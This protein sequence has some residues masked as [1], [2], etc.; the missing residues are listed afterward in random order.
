MLKIKNRIDSELARF[1]ESADKF[2]SLKK[3]S[4]LLSRTI[5]DFVSREGKRVRPALFIIAYLGFTKNK[6]KNLY[7]SSLS[8]E[9]LHDFLLIHDDIIDKSDLRRNKPSMHRIFDKHLKRYNNLKFTGED[10]AIVAGDMLYALSIEALMSIKEDSKRKE[11]ALKKFIEAA[12]FTE[13]GEFIELLEGARGI[14]RV[15]KSTIYKIYDFKTAHYTFSSPLS[16]GAILAGADKKQIETLHQFGMSLGR[17]FQIRDDILNILAEEKETGKSTLTDLKEA[18]KTILIWFAYN[19]SGKKDKAF[20]KKTLLK[21]NI[22]R[23]N[24]LKMKKLIT[25]T[26]SLDYALR[27]IKSLLAKSEKIIRQSKMKLK[28]K[29]MLINYCGQ[30]LNYK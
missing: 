21:K 19:R 8:V 18:K 4:P 1:V 12:F 22:S 16:I 30:L 27:Q 25:D 29:N 14:D 7:R 26:G 28:Y 10:L 9:L 24:L 11:R 13:A 17:A 6:A 5:K 23:N 3:I 20:I 2:Y 15:K